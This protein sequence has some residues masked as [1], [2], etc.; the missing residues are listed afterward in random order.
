VTIHKLDAEDLGG[1]EGSADFDGKVGG[2]CGAGLVFEGS[3]VEELERLHMQLY[4]VRSS[5]RKPG[6][7]RMWR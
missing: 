4:G 7:G 5:G 1:G 2:L 6:L 3:L